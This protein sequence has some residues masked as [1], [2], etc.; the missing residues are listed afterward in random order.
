MIIMERM[1]LLNDN[2][3]TAESAQTK[4]GDSK[5]PNNKWRDFTETT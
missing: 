5:K 2:D 1:K 4:S 3:E